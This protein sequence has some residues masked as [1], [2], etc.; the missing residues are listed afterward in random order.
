MTGFNLEKLIEN[1][2][3]GAQML[4]EPERTQVLKALARRRET[5]KLP[6]RSSTDDKTEE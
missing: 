6:P 4:P 2:E 5:Y 3:R 1:S